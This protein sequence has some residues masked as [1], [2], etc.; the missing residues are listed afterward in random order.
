ML[1]TLWATEKRALSNAKV[2][3]NCNNNPNML[4]ENRCTDL[5]WCVQAF[6]CGKRKTDLQPIC[7]SGGV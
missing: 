6:K 1:A 2:Q 4:L 7:I 3:K 5:L